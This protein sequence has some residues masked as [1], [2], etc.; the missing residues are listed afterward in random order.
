MSSITI[1]NNCITYSLYFLQKNPSLLDYV[2]N[3]THNHNTDR[4][5]FLYNNSNEMNIIRKELV[6]NGYSGYI[7]PASLQ[8]CEK[9]LNGKL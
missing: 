3:F 6:N 9:M 8:E 4:T 7:I 1:I 2:K 5:G